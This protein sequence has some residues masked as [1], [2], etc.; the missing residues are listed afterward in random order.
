M[1]QTEN[2]QGG[3][4]ILEVSVASV[5]SMVGLLCLA[6][7][8]TLSIS[9]NRVVKQFS[10]TTALAQEKLEQL[11]TFERSDS[12][13]SAGGSLNSALT[14]GTLQYSDDVFVD[15]TGQVYI[16][17]NIPSG[18]KAQYRRFWAVQNS[19]TLT[20]TMI[21]AVRVVALQAGRNSGKAEETTL[22]SVRSW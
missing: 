13:L 20:N 21:V 14:V 9:Q 10:S 1:K 8:F 17:A 22:M 5:V 6:G 7:L 3:F 2:T 11:T 16:N 19:P 15:D 12:R 18:S 4:T